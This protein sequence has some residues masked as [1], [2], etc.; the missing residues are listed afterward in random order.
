M[1]ARAHPSIAQDCYGFREAGEHPG[2]LRGGNADG[3][4]EA[5]VTEV[6]ALVKD[7]ECPGAIGKVHDVR[8]HT[9]KPSAGGLAFDRLGDYTKTATREAARLAPD[10]RNPPVAE[11][12]PW[13]C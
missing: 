9:S 11:E 5:L 3:Q 10:R 6:G 7:E 4:R 8:R 12:E 2:C 13:D 1:A